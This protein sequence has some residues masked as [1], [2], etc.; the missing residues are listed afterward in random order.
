MKEGNALG[1]PGGAGMLGD[2]GEDTVQ[3]QPPELKNSALCF[4]ESAQELSRALMLARKWRIWQ[5]R[6]S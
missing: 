3:G 4:K 2:V 6:T 1:A 5:C